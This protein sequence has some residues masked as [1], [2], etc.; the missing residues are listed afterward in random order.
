MATK[1][2]PKFTP[3]L[4]RPTARRGFLL[5]PL[6]L[7]AAIGALCLALA[8]MSAHGQAAEA[9]D[10]DQ[11]EDEVQAAPTQPADDVPPSGDADAA[12]EEIEEVVVTG[13]RIK[14]STYTSI[15][16]LQ[17]IRADVKREA[18]LIDAAEIIQE[19][20]ASSGT[21]Y[22]LTF[23][24]FVLDDGPGASTANLRGLGSGRTL[25]LLNSRRLAPTGVEGA[26]TSPNLKIVP[27]L[28]V[29]QYDQLLDGASSIYGSDAIAGVLNILLKKDFDGW[30]VE[31]APS[32]PHHDGGDSQSLGVSWGR[33]W[34]RGFVGVGVQHSDYEPVTLAQRPWTAGCERDIEVDE[35]GRIRHA[36]LWNHVHY[37]MRPMKCKPT[38]YDRRLVVPRA[39]YVYYTPGRTNG[40]WPN[41][42]E[43]NS[44]WW[45]G[46]FPMDTDGDGTPDVDW[47]D[48]NRNGTRQH[49]HLFTE[50][51]TTNSMAYGE[52]TFEGEANLTP[53]FEV[54][55]GTSQN[56]YDSGG[57]LPFRPWIPARNPYNLCNPDAPGGVDCGRAMEAMYRNPGFLRDFSKIAGDY[58]TSW[59]VPLDRCSPLAFRWGQI[60]DLGPQ[61]IRTI[62]AVRDD[63]DN[64]R[65][66]TTWMRGVVGLQGDL[67][68]L[69][70]GSLSDWTFDLSLTHSSS[71]A[72]SHR[73]GIRQDR[74][75]LALGYYSNDW[76]PCENN[77]SEA[78]RASRTNSERN[79]L[80]PITS[81][82]AAPGCVPVNMLAG[83]LFATPIGDFGTAAERDYLFDSRDFDT[84]YKQTLFSAHATGEL[85]NLPAGAVASSVGI[86]YRI[87][88]IKS[89]PDE[90]A[91]DGLFW[92]FFTDGGAEGDKYTAEFFSEVDLPLLA[93]KPFARELTTNL[94]A[95]F[96]R[97]EFYGG[98]WTSAAKVGWRPIDSLLIRA[99]YGTSYRAPNLRDLFLRGQSGFFTVTDP[100]FVPEDAKEQVPGGTQRRYNPALDTRDEHVL[101]RCRDEGVD[102]TVAGVGTLAWYSVESS[103]GGSL[104]LDEETSESTTYGFAWEQPFTN[105]FGLTLG[106]TY[107]ETDIENTIIGPS[108]GFIVY[109]CYI[110]QQSAGQ[111]CNRITRNLNDKDN[112]RMRHIDRGFVNRDRER[113][114]GVDVNM[115]ADTTVTV[116]D[117]PIDLS[118]EVNG[119]RLIERTTLYV[120]DAGQRTSRRY[121]G[122][123]FYN[124]HKAEMALRVDYDRWRLSWQSRYLGSN[125]GYHDF[126]PVFGDVQENT[127]PSSTCLGPPT[128]MQCKDVE[129]APDY[130]IHHAAFTYRG[131][132]WQIVGG[133]RNVFDK[134]PPQ[135]DGNWL[136]AEI[137]NTPRGAG[138]DLNGRVYFVTAT[139]N[140][141]RNP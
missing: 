11:A 62:V 124:R 69:R 108:A 71:Q 50:Y 34:D 45:V 84:R 141:A 78:T 73:L 65:T 10:S 61:T 76:K 38:A 15:A 36:Y 1:S 74:I 109:D 100:C 57:D 44:N 106:M 126:E 30:T 70:F 133:L 134:A 115:T 125:I 25:V 140:F 103:A 2:Q 128:D 87:D 53:Y 35:G 112:P 107:Y 13:S 23:T 129:T 94:S 19:S 16:P 82:D 52:Y 37:G 105:A 130:W 83:S 54:L 12:Y 97:D 77:I 136:W 117:R 132:E 116:F 110:S 101:Q 88:E 127:P 96:T 114:R 63:R 7:C 48:H 47:A 91:R 111:F 81:A 32:V 31:L 59:G 29:Q 123:W 102:P 67:P 58:C 4:A 120:N 118:F 18:G 26:P 20:S 121:A 56:F 138:Y 39:G 89:I 60:G 49:R 113:V 42:S 72:E 80:K 64:I 68:L 66:E 8:P 98:A 104:T 75:E 9:G 131:D 17:I 5:S 24:G 135:V 90:V 92:G 93:G 21:Q 139:L 55:L 33:N 79:P 85:F 51:R 46:R 122:Q 95:R 28:L 3:L 99:T 41:F 86:E 40:G 14:R 137:N 43:S 119:H 6:P 22:D 27:G